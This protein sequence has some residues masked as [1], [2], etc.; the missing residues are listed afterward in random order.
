[1]LSDHERFK[2]ILNGVQSLVL[3][4]AVVVGGVWTLLVFDVLEQVERARAELDVL[5]KQAAQ[6]PAMEVEIEAE[7]VYLEG[8]NRPYL[9]ARVKIANVG[10]RNAR[11]L[12]PP[13]RFPF[14]VIPVA[15]DAEGMQ[16]GK[17][18]GAG[19][20]SSKKP[21][22]LSTG[23]VIRAGS[24]QIFPFFVALPGPGVYLLAYG[25]QVGTEDVLDDVH[26]AP[27]DNLSFWEGRRFFVAVGRTD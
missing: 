13:D 10:T 20:A 21:D 2:N 6:Q 26:G 3:S 14:A 24:A 17:R 12:Y 16:Y 15:F 22:V 5:R 18:I 4:V 23:A 27:S 8:G 9:S 1:M 19:L 11:L 7:E 25:V